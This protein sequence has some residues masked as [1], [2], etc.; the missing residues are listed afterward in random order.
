MSCPDCDLLVGPPVCGQGLRSYFVERPPPERERA[1]VAELP[2]RLAVMLEASITERARRETRDWRQRLQRL[3]IQ[4]DEAAAAAQQAGT[5]E[6]EEEL[7]ELPEEEML[8]DESGEGPQERQ[9]QAS[10][11]PPRP[12]SAVPR[13]AGYG[14]AAPP[15]Q[16]PQRQQPWQQQQE[17]RGYGG[18]APP[19]YTRG[20]GA[21]AP[22]QQQQQPV[23]SNGRQQQQ[24]QA[25]MRSSNSTWG[26]GRF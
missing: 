5:G 2:D 8:Q 3:E 10:I 20:S 6:G 24:Y 13:T 26:P 1:V 17:R 14:R 11:P 19:R 15:Q 4:Y 9:L 21:P 23:R 7:E 22:Q 16:Q 25:P 18:P 12:P